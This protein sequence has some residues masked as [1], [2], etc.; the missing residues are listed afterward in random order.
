M[1]KIRADAPAI[2]SPSGAV[3]N[4]IPLSSISIFTPNSLVIPWI[5]SPPLP[6]TR[7]ISSG[8]ILIVSIRG[9]YLLSSLRTSGI[10]ESISL[11]IDARP[12][13]AF[14]SASLKTPSGSPFT[15]ISIWIAVTP[16]AVPVTL[17]SISPPKSSSS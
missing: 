12:I 4:T 17:K 7:R 6:I 15:L 13:F 8:S 2:D 11:R 14:S 10:A 1:F 16:A 5:V 3:T 9:A